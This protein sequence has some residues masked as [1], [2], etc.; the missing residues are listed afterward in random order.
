MTTD[1][2]EDAVARALARL[3][4]VPGQAAVAARWQAEWA[5]LQVPPEPRIVVTGDAK[6]GRSTLLN[7]ILG[8]PLLRTAVR[9]CTPVPVTV[10]ADG[11]RL[12]EV[13]PGVAADPGDGRVLVVDLRQPLPRRS[14]VVA[15]GGG[16][17]VVVL[18]K[19]DRARAD[20]VL[21]HDV[22]AELV[23]A[24]QEAE[25][26]AR[27]R[28]AGPLVDVVVCDA[29]DAQAVPEVVW[30]R[31]RDALSSEVVRRAVA[32][33]EAVRR[34]WRAAVEA[35]LAVETGR[36][37]PPELPVAPAARRVAQAALTAAMA[38]L[39]LDRDAWL[40]GVS[41]VES[42]AALEQRL[43]GVSD[44]LLAL[45]RAATD[46]AAD[47]GGR[48]WAQE[49]N[50]LRAGVDAAWLHHTGVAPHGDGPPVRPPTA[51][52]DFGGQR[53]ASDGA[54]KVRA[55]GSGLLPGLARL[56]RVSVRRGSVADTWRAV[57]AELETDLGAALWDDVSRWEA[58]LRT[59]AAD[60]VAWR[61]AQGRDA[62]LA[63]ARARSE[64]L[65]E[66][67]RVRAVLRGDPVDVE[68]PSARRL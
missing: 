52:R 6:A 49:V 16:P 58:A 65:V 56:R 29:R 48:A 37:W 32:R 17:S 3:A 8:R 15:D 12:T 1:G 38:T 11:W 44:A 21:S 66:V 27:R 60:H 63:A 33:R 51:A 45:L 5:A 24:V 31:V 2:A 18:T 35:A 64:A 59:A 10:F 20:A 36:H 13:P 43:D 34:R 9:A 54:A 7:H 39:A 62:L 26:R 30:P 57:T 68:S 47:A 28:C 25:R 53:H 41:V 55:A 19:A 67:A 22:E 40:A 42:H 14:R 4:R 23:E 46:R 61:E 50:T